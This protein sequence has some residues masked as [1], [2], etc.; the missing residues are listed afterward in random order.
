MHS[1]YF[2]ELHKL[3]HSATEMNIITVAREHPLVV[4][5][6]ILLLALP[7]YIFGIH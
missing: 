2:W 6:S 7:A 1:K 3:H 5:V 4:I